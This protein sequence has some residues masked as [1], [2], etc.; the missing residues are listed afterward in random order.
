MR[1]D[2]EG[3]GGLSLRTPALA[4]H[5]LRGEKSQ[6]GTRGRKVPSADCENGDFSFSSQTCS[7][8]LWQYGSLQMGVFFLYL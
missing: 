5:P 2:G 3:W 6:H 8:L 4:A 7:Q 1:D